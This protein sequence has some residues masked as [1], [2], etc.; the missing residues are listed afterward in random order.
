MSALF[1]H[2]YHI[3]HHRHLVL[4][5][6]NLRKILEKYNGQESVPFNSSVLNKMDSSLIAVSFSNP[7]QRIHFMAGGTRTMDTVS[8]GAV[9][10]SAC[11]SLLLLS[12]VGFVFR[13]EMQVEV[14][15]H[16]VLRNHGVAESTF[17]RAAA[18]AA[19]A[20]AL[21]RRQLC[22]HVTCITQLRAPE[23]L[24]SR[25]KPKKTMYYSCPKQSLHSLY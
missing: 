7:V 2:I 15:V 10:A 16:S 1:A 17:I 23:R 8:L 24:Q 14:A 4:E 12:T 19:A 6:K 21:R 20:A 11:Q 18:A 13:R 25:G 22:P 9:V 3:M 5:K